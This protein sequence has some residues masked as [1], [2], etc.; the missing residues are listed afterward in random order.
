[1][2]K[3]TLNPFANA[4]RTAQGTGGGVSPAVIEEMQAEIEILGSENSSQ[5]Q[6]ITDI[7]AQLAGLAAPYSVTEHK[8]GRKWTNGADIYEKTLHY[9]GAF[10]LDIP[11]TGVIVEYSTPVTVVCKAWCCNGAGYVPLRT[12]VASGD[13]LVHAIADTVTNISDVTIEYVK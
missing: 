7:K 2:E 8:T 11:T 9:E 3:C 6:D 5:T 13:L 4:K 12:S 10:T 1:M